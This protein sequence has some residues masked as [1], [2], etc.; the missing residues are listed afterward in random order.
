MSEFKVESSFPS[1]KKSVA[2]ET[3]TVHPSDSEEYESVDK[4]LDPHDF[5]AS[6]TIQSPNSPTSPPEKPSVNFDDQFLSNENSLLM[7]TTTFSG[8][9]WAELP[10]WSYHPLQHTNTLN[11]MSM[12]LSR[13]SLNAPLPTMNLNHDDPLLFLRSQESKYISSL[14]HLLVNHLEFLAKGHGK[15]KQVRT[16][17]LDHLYQLQEIHQAMNEIYYSERSNR[18]NLLQKFEDWEL[19]KKMILEK[20][21]DI[22]S[23]SNE[24]GV[25]FRQLYE[26]SAQ[27]DSEIEELES[28]LKQLKQK[29]NVIRSELTS[30]QSVL[31]SKASSYIE[32]LDVI[33]SD[34]KSLIN[35]LSTFNSDNS[36]GIPDLVV[37]KNVS[38]VSTA[39]TNHDITDETLSIMDISKLNFS[40]LFNKVKTNDTSSVDDILT[41]TFKPQVDLRPVM[42]SLKLQI[43][44]LKDELDRQEL[45]SFKF[46]ESAIVWSESIGN[47]TSMET[48]LKSNGRIDEPFLLK[49]LEQ[50][51]DLLVKRLE[52]SSRLQLTAVKKAIFNEI[53]AIKKLL[54]IITNDDKYK[55]E[56]ADS[57]TNTPSSLSSSSVWKTKTLSNSS[58]NKNLAVGIPIPLHNGSLE[59]AGVFLKSNNASPPTTTLANPAPPTFLVSK[60]NGYIDEKYKKKK[61]SIFNNL[62]A[63]NSDKNVKN[64]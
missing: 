49:T 22:K 45:K 30:S 10:D 54:F 46:Q 19:K 47:V 1:R 20:I 33:E 9:N 32:S 21:N 50:T 7:N 13:L 38:P 2:Q 15:V 29:R 27:L 63:S 61:P 52:T 26:T 51:L 31:E 36:M 34:E 12:N 39:L 8:S 48:S 56:V 64:D 16:I 55:E 41:Q 23:D 25:R 17:I 40:K 59:D 35:R 6:N 58:S 18:V 24:E 53:S 3:P 14:N 57:E 43:D 42:D 5:L 62:V 28:K 60:P 37:P 4:E 44:A 11:N